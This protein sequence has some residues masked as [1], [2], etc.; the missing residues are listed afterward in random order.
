MEQVK[1]K[2]E[3]LAGKVEPENA[4]LWNRTESLDLRIVDEASSGK[5]ERER[6]KINYAKDMGLEG[7]KRQWG[8]KMNGRLWTVCNDRN[9]IEEHRERWKNMPEWTRLL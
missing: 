3:V 2:Q 9:S 5:H 1:G 4:E 7:L 8:G 6:D